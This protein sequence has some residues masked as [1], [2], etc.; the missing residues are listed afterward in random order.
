MRKTLPIPDYR[1]GATSVFDRIMRRLEMEALDKK[2]L[3]KQLNRNLSESEMEKKITEIKL[4][5]KNKEVQSISGT[6][7]ENRVFFLLFKCIVV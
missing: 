5:S 1:D 7:H 6:F 4:R 2:R 3:E